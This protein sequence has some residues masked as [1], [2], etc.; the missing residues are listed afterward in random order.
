MNAVKNA[1]LEGLL[2]GGGAALLHATRA[3]QALE[4]DNLDE[5]LGIRTLALALREPFWAIL[6]NA[7]LCP[8]FF[9]DKLTSANNWRN[10]VCVRRRE[11][12]DMVDGGVD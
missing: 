12:I 6:G 2:P 10:G 11:I 1:A 9:A 7:G 5:T 8:G 4:G 3:I